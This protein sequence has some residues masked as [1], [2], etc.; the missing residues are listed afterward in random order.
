MSRCN[1][2][3]AFTFGVVAVV[4]A[5]SLL[6]PE[7]SIDGANSNTILGD[8]AYFMP[9]LVA[10]VAQGRALSA[11]AYLM[12]RTPVGPT[13]RRLLLLDNGITVLRELAA[14]MPD[15]A[16]LHQPMHRLNKNALALHEAAAASSPP[17]TS[18]QSLGRPT[19]AEFGGPFNPVGAAFW[20]ASIVKHLHL[21]FMRGGNVTGLLHERLERADAAQQT[22][23]MF[24]DWPPCP[25]CLAGMEAAAGRSQQRY[26]AKAPLSIWDGVPVAFKD[27][28]KVKGYIMSDG[29]GAH[30]P[31]FDSPATEDDILVTRFRELG[32]II[33]P[34]TTMT[35]GGVTPVGYSVAPGG[36]LNPYNSS[37][38]SG[39]SSGGSAVAVALGIVPVAIGFDGGGSIRTPAAL[40]GVVGL[41]TGYG[42]V[43]FT[44]HTQSTMIKS[45]P[46]AATVADAALA[47]AVIA[48]KDARAPFYDVM[49]DGGVQGTPTAHLKALVHGLHPIKPD[50]DSSEP[51]AAVRHSLHGV[52]LGIFPEWFDD[53]SP[54]VREKCHAAVDKLVSL[55]A[56]VKNVTIPNLGWMRLAHAMKIST[57][58]AIGWDSIYN[59]RV[60]GRMLEGN[61]RITVGLG[62]SVS[63][64]EI[65]AAEKL[66][67][68]AF[69]HVNGL[70]AAGVD[71]I[72]TPTTSISA[73][74]CSEDS[75]QAGESNS[76][77]TVELLKYVFLGNYLG[78]P[79]VSVPVGFD[80]LN[81]RMPV[82]LMFSGPHWSEDR[83]LKLAS[84]FKPLPAPKFDAGPEAGASLFEASGRHGIGGG[85]GG[86]GHDEH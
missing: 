24:S 59:D 5:I 58:F 33:L 47:Y 22:H 25:A 15:V 57:E 84:Y 36:P 43:P 40:S 74:V 17:I 18:F 69:E 55:G 11:M 72:V 13:I 82:G 2:R 85:G 50:D 51:D 9:A 48:S 27:M 14:Q 76:P 49:Y 77:L 80:R 44:S 12:T 56:V 10:P 30:G 26:D 64:I 67:A 38:H 42:R 75:K 81:N 20:D 29:S 70:F 21:E 35:E 65:L 73:P 6:S 62:S 60:R 63:A 46:L 79:G 71:A 16:P 41:A 34:P 86:G 78:L 83:L 45:G 61:T 32:A 37:H 52:T 53:S 19:S 31:A 8:P 23:R 54:G 3:V 7:H 1:C 66:R 68:Y 39:G 4:V 28:I